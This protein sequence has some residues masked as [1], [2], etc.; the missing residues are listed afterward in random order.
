M[1]LNKLIYGVL[2]VCALASCADQMDY[3]EYNP[4]DADYVKRT[5]YDVGGLVSNIYQSLESDFGSYSGAVLG[6]ATDESQYAYTGNSIETFYNGSWSPVNAQS[7]VWTS[8]YKAIANCN[9]YLENFT[10]LTFSEYEQLSDYRAEMN[11]YN[12]YQYEVRFL[13]AYFYFNLARQYGDIPFTDHLLTTAEVN[14]LTRKPVQEVFDWIIGECDAIKDLIIADYN[15]LGTLLPSGEAA[16]TGRANKRT[17][18]ALKARTA[19]YAASPLFNTNAEGS[20]AY[21]ALWHRAASAC[22][23]LIEACEAS[24]MKLIDNYENLWVSNSYSVAIDELIFGCRANRATNTF[25]KNNFPV[26]IEN[27]NGGNCPT[28]TLVDAYELKST[29]AR[30]DASAD[31]SPTNPYY[32]DDRDPRFGMTIAKNG[33]TKWPNWH[34]EALEIYQG[35]ANAEPLSGGT[36]T[37]YYL[38]KYCQT[39]INTT[40][41][42]PTTGFHTWIIYRMGEFYL[43]YAEALFRYFDSPYVTNDEFPQPANEFVNKTR[44]RSS[45]SMPVFPTGMSKEDWWKKYQNERMVELAF[46]GHRFWDVRRWKEGDKHFKSI[47]QMKITRNPNNTYSYSRVTVNRQWDDKMYLFPIPQTEL[48]K[49]TNLTQNPGW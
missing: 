33:D 34:E 15:N 31:Y 42:K 30:P 27:C 24:G 40:T 23:E 18:L 14:T 36:P 45:V 32:V 3:S 11:R 1:K 4:Y 22:K 26:G 19:L 37:G 12:N 35:G 5:F 2:S 9:D 44:R 41:A 48:A 25:E 46:E 39:A 6:S 47:D 10:G 49:N 21:K 20:E 16:E 38:K 17:V 8:S 7:S 29:N 28:Q 13:R 43:N